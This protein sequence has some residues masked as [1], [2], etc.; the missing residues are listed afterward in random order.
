MQLKKTGNAFSNYS[1]APQTG[2]GAGDGTTTGF[3]VIEAGNDGD[4]T[5][6]PNTQFVTFQ[7]GGDENVT[8][9]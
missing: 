5:T 1:I 6:L 9:A 2:V 4:N 7:E 8:A 3:S